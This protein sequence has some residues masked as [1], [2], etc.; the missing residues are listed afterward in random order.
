MKM[1]RNM[2]GDYI[3]GLDIFRI[4]IVHLLLLGALFILSAFFFCGRVVDY[5]ASHLWCIGFLIVVLVSLS[6]LV[7]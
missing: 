5:V 6:I 4:T 1:K 7:G 2:H 3:Y